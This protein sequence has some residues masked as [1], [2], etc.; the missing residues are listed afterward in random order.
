MRFFVYYKKEP[1]FRNNNDIR[2]IVADGDFT[3]EYAFVGT[4]F[5]PDKDVVFPRMQGEMWSPQG[6][7]RN[8]I[9][10]LGLSHTS[11][12]VGDVIV[13]DNGDMFE[14]SNI[15]WRAI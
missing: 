3:K 6:E 10:A 12:S 15:G 13:D 9:K 1:A 7:A 14:C 4:Q 11:M 5:A 8:L 2:R